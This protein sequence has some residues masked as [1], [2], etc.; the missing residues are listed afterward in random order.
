MSVIYCNLVIMKCSVCTIILHWSNLKCIPL[1]S[2]DFLSKLLFVSWWGE[3]NCSY[4]KVFLCLRFCFN[5]FWDCFSVLSVVMFSMSLYG[6]WS[7]R[8][9]KHCRYKINH[10]SSWYLQKLQIKIFW[11]MPEKRNKSRTN[12]E[13]LCFSVIL[14][15]GF[16]LAWNRILCMELYIN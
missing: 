16:S 4:K 8:E 6:F 9:D 3:K 12:L 14:H 15:E 2:V 11:H 1:V 7:F 10:Y 13:G 5:Y